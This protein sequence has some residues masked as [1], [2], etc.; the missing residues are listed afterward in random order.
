MVHKSFFEQQPQHASGGNNASL[1]P[2]ACRIGSSSKADEQHKGEEE[3]EEQ[4]EPLPFE[5]E[6]DAVLQALRAREA[7]LLRELGESN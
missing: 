1:V 2:R 5:M 4:E 6:G 3:E 7:G